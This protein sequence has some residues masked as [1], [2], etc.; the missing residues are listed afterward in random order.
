MQ[1]KAYIILVKYVKALSSET[2]VLGIPACP[3]R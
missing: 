3:V 1:D 2:D